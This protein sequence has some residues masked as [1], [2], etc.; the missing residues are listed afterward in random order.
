MEEPI[1][2]F[3]G[4]LFLI[5]LKLFSAVSL[6]FFPQMIP[7]FDDGFYSDGLLIED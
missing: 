7:I 5:R 4:R 1:C 3:M 6:F 2:V